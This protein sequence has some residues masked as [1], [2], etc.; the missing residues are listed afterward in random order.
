MPWIPV[1]H[2][3]RKLRE[4]RGWSLQDLE[5]ESGVSVRSITAIESRKPPSF[6]KPQNAEAIS[7]AF[8]LKLR[9]YN[10]WPTSSRWI[11]WHATRDAR[12]VDDDVPQISAV[13]TLSK[14]AKIERQRGLHA[15][16]MQTSE[17]PAN[18]LGLDRLDKV[19]SMPKAHMGKVFAVAGK[20]DQHMPMPSSAAKKIGAGEDDGVIY[21]IT[22]AV[23][24]NLPIYVTVYAPTAE[25]A[26]RLMTAYDDGERVV[27][28]VRVVYDP[29]KGPWRGFFFIE[30]GPPKA[31]KFAFVIEKLVTEI[32]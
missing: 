26:Q 21:R 2:A 25:I 10:D 9:E 24:K 18:L 32:K 14:S 17:G 6:V 20:V 5:D 23:A 11:V 13:G 22:R 31:K 3:L 4:G 12:A 1:K 27:M 29:Y 30:D 15:I 16:M 28:L 19:F 7:L 8:G